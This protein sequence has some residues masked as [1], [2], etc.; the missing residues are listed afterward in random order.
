MAAST[1]DEPL[2]SLATMPTY[3]IHSRDDEVVPFAPAE[4]SARAL[5]K[6]GRPIR[7]EALQDIGHFEMGAYVEPLRRAGRWVADRW[8]K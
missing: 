4:R 3:V 5:E 8:K 7:F 2:E 6:L 1:G